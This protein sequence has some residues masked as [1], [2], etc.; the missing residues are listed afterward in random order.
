VAGRTSSFS[1]KGKN[2]DLRELGRKLGVAS[3]LEGS[4]RKAGDRVRITTQLVSVQD[5]YHV[6]S[7]TFDRQLKDV[8]A[9]QQEIATAVAATLKT[10]LLPSAA[11]PE[12]R[13]ANP[14]A[15]EQ[16]LVGK[17][18]MSQLTDAGYRGALA[19]FRRVTDLDPGFAPAWC[20][21]STA[22]FNLSLTANEDEVPA[23]R[24]EALAMV[25][26]CV[27]VAP[28]SPHGL[29]WRGIVRL[30]TLGDFRGGGQ[31]IERAV[32]MS[33]HDPNVLDRQA[34]LLADLGRMKEAIAL[35]HTVVESD[36]L[37]AI[38]WTWLAYYLI[39]AN[40]LDGAA[41]AAAK[42]EEV[43]PGSPPATRVR[44]ALQMAR[45]DAQGLLETS[46][47]ANAKDGLWMR[48][49]ALHGLGREKESAEATRQFES[50]YGQNHADVVAGLHAQRGEFDAA[51]DWIERAERQGSPIDSLKYWYPLRPLH[52]DPRFSALLRK[53]GLPAD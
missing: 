34:H 46:T 39:G 28:D 5:G 29:S 52:A 51:F 7:Q 43:A 42:V 53:R 23:L 11:D 6:W 41:Q 35:Q 26:K 36:R 37:N 24:R 49:I 38:S 47:H 27:A 20:N 32:A 10:K 30:R 3:V 44:G 21:I 2:E 50:T 15:Y 19:A 48:A 33:P 25:E 22:L 1:F 8:F 14:E 45:G 16:Y 18:L 13:T 31:D 9:V 4:V 17:K 12:R 40:D